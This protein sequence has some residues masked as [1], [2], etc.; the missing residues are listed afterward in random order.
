MRD[1]LK[2]G[3]MNKGMRNPRQKKLVYILVGLVI[4]SFLVSIVAV[5]FY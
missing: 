2:M 1:D 4:L 5:G 3:F